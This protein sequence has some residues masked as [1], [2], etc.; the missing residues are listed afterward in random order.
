MVPMGPKIFAA[1]LALIGL[2]YFGQISIW[3]VAH[4]VAH[5][6]GVQADGVYVVGSVDIASTSS[7]LDLGRLRR[8]LRDEDDNLS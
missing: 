4:P 2:K 1:L 5:P 3:R 6:Q 7:G 8:M